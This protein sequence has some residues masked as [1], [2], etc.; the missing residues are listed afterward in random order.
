[1]PVTT[2]RPPGRYYADLNP[3][4]PSGHER[5]WVVWANHGPRERSP[6]PSMFYQYATRRAAERCAARLN[7]QDRRDVEGYP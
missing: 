3:S 2:A 4:F 7:E 6:L 1:M 5:R